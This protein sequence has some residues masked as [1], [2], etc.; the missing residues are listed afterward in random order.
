MSELMPM[1]MPMSMFGPTINDFKTLNLKLDK[2]IMRSSELAE[3]LNGV[4]AQ[5]KKAATE[6]LTKIED[7]TA[8]IADQE[9][10]PDAL[11]ALRDLKSSVQALD[12]I[13][14]DASPEPPPD[15]PA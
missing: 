6:I 2:L 7:L 4:R 11:A 8:D 13:V 12:D 15:E 9:L 14:P 1:F 3:A 10:S 5:I